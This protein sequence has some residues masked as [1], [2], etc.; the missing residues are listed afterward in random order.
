MEPF[1]LMRVSSTALGV[2]LA[3]LVMGAA[4]SSEQGT[5]LSPTPP[6]G[7]VPDTP[8]SNPTPT[9]PATPPP[10]TPSGR[11]G[12]LLAVGDIGEC[13]SPGVEQT[14]R[15]IR[16]LEGDLVMAGDLAYM[17]GSMQDFLRCFEP[18]YGQFRNRWRPVPGNHE[19]GTPG[20]AGYFQYFGP[21]GSHAG[22]SFYSFTSG[23]WLVL[24][25]DSSSHGGIGAG[26][27]QFEFVRSQLRAHR[28]PCTMAVWHHPLFTSGPNGPNVFM[29]D[30]WGLLYE[31]GA[32]VVVAAH[33]HFYE[34]FG[35][36]DVDGRSD[37]RGLR[38]FIVGT[39]GAR[40]YDVM[41]MTANSQAR[42]RSYGVTQL[43]LNFNSYEWRFIDG[44]GN[45]LDAGSDSCH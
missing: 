36:Q 45:T 39:G 1:N 18:F 25:L 3:V 14:S 19:Y 22:R 33:D 26:S 37:A 16:G 7:N 21:A 30:M 38:Q 27:E 29:R 24:M 4:C 40:L 34:R 5:P 42:H 32:D 2:A 11:I 20:A 28:N 41:R 17:S 43:T 15:V 12:R 10:P 8:P 9:P 6:T 31:N 44:S 35:K 23:D 13:G